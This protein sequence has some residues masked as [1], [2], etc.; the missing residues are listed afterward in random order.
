MKV[1]RQGVRI[2]DVPGVEYIHVEDGKV[3]VRY[4]FYDTPI[5][6]GVSEL[7]SFIEALQAAQ[8]EAGG[9]PEQPAPKTGSPR[10]FLP[11]DDIPA[12]VTRVRDVDSSIW[13]RSQ[14]HGVWDGE[15]LGDSYQHWTRTRLLNNFAPLTEV[16]P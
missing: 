12:D 4:D 2:T 1:E 7:A 6:Y 10:V 16:L 5:A 11:G 14:I 13:N 8:T 9:S 3:A 15:G